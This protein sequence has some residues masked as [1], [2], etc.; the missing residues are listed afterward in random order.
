MLCDTVAVY[1]AF[2]EDLL[3][4]EKIVLQVTDAGDTV[5]DETAK[6]IRCAMAWKDQ[7][8]FEALVAERVTGAQS[9][10]S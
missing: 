7:A 10:E 8:A 9:M 2:S 1:L 3:T 4:M 6:P 5:I